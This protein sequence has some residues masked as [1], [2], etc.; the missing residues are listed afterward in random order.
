M[1]YG[2]QF[3]ALSFL[4]GLLHVD[5]NTAYLLIGTALVIGTPFFVIFGWLSD[6]IGRKTV[7]L[8]GLLLACIGYLPLFHMLTAAVNPALEKAQASAPVIVAADPAACALQFDPVGKTKFL[9][10]CDIAK[11]YLAKGGVSYSNQ[12]APPAAWPSSGSAASPCRP[13]KA[14]A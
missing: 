4:T 9:Q 1:W 13:T 8:T 7:I 2:G 3:Y 10:S 12:A 5:A 6:R 14:R 11:S